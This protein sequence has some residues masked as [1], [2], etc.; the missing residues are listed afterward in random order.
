MAIKFGTDMNVSCGKNYYDSCA[1]LTFHSVPL[2][3]QI[4]IG[5]AICFVIKNLQN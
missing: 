5:S 2:S 3:G 4:F 1:P